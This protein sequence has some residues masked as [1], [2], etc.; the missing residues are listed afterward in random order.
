MRGDCLTK[1]RKN[2]VGKIFGRLIVKEQYED[3]ISPLGK[4]LT[5]WLCECNCEK[6]NKVVVLGCNLVKGC[7]KSCGCLKQQI[8]STR[9]NK[10]NE[11][12]IQ[13]DYVIMYTGK[14]EPFF[15]DL[16]DFWKVRDICWHKNDEGYIVAALNGKTTRIHRLIMDAPNGL[17]VDHKYGKETRNDNRKYNLRI[18]TRSQ[19]NVNRDIQKN[20]TSG[21]AGVYKHSQCDKWTANV[22]RNNKT[23]YLGLFDTKEEAIAARK[24]AEN[25]YYG[26]FSYDNSQTLVNSS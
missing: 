22:W 5:Q 11:Y 23:I 2:L 25:K 16:E 24:D 7:T 9:L 21:T 19:N 20:N 3:Y 6:H 18:A 26:E 12:E 14:G 1:V 13:E 10:T 17:D 4:H 8:L 15:V